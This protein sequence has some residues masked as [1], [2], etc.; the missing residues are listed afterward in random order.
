MLLLIAE[1]TF[2]PINLPKFKPMKQKL[3]LLGFAEFF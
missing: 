3:I 1:W 2:F